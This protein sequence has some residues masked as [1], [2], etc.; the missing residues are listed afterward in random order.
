MQ[1]ENLAETAN[2][3]LS[4]P[5]NF[6]GVDVGKVT[7]AG[8]PTLRVRRA[9]DP[10]EFKETIP[11]FSEPNRM[12]PSDLPLK[13]KD[14]YNMSNN[15]TNSSNANLD[16][17]NFSRSIP[18]SEV[19]HDS[20]RND[21][22]RIQTRPRSIS[23]CEMCLE[24]TFAFPI[25]LLYTACTEKE[26]LSEWWGWSR[27]LKITPLYM[28]LHR[29]GIFHYRAEHVEDMMPD[30]LS[31]DLNNVFGVFVFKEIEPCKRLE[32]LSGFADENAS[33]VRAYFNPRWPMQIRNV[34][35]FH[36]VGP[37]MTRMVISESPYNATQDELDCFF[38][39][40]SHMEEGFSRMFNQLEEYLENV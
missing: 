34:W 26:S 32:F 21:S 28:N 18:E 39:N 22:P 13:E 2:R 8:I 20:P 27:D 16:N 15:H 17:S 6:S 4:D 11:G 31:D 30:V 40:I 19:K 29:G 37:G 25:S 14:M 23:A 1:N 12:G 7:T 5:Q 38:N 36:E 35:T 9:S 10:E 33:F 3:A 24:R